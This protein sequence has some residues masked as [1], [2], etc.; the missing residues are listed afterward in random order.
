MATD[1][2]PGP[3]EDPL[4]AWHCDYEAATSETLEGKP[5]VVDMPQ[6]DI[7]QARFGLLG[8][9]WQYRKAMK[10]RRNLAR[11]G[12][13][14]WFLID[15]TYPEPKFVKPEARGGDF[16]EIRQDGTPYFFPREAAVADERTGMYTYV[17]KKGDADPINL[18]DPAKPAVPSGRLKEWL[19]MELHKDPPSWLDNLDLDGKDVFIACLGLVVLIAVA[20]P[21]IAG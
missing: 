10:K 1:A 17:H 7:K 13:I 11:K 12:Y 5:K 15:E 8:Q 21:L 16:P 9:F 14:R 4:D 2:D 20:Y 18:Q 6:P 3:A 19:Q